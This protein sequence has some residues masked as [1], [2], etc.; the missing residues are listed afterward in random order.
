VRHEGRTGHSSEGRA[1][2]KRALGDG[3]LEIGASWTGGAGGIRRKPVKVTNRMA[4]VS[5]LL[6]RE[7]KAERDCRRRSADWKPNTAPPRRGRGD[8]KGEGG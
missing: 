7:R 3:G 4:G 6:R 8:K 2:E 5:A 1:E